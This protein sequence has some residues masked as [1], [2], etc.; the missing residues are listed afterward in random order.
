MNSPSIVVRADA[1]ASIGN[2]HVYRCLALVDQFRRDYSADALFICREHEG[3]DADM[4]T[5]HGYSVHSF[6]AKE[7]FK[8]FD[9]AL[10]YLHLH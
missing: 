2:G 7:D 1:G 5:R 4:I 3:F 10:K 8:I 6:E 9:N